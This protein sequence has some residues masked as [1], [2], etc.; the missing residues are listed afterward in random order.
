MTV[1]VSN[2]QKLTVCPRCGRGPGKVIAL[3]AECL[4]DPHPDSL[5]KADE[6]E[7]LAAAEG[8]LRDHHI[9]YHTRP[10]WRVMGLQQL[11]LRWLRWGQR[12]DQP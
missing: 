9:K 8:Y 4:T 7:A 5:G 6:T 1:Q 2:E 12:R 11:L 10:A 3:Q